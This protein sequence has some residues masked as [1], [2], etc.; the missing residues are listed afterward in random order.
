[1]KLPT[2]EVG[3][4]RRFEQEGLAHSACTAPY[5]IGGS[6]LLWKGAWRHGDLWK[7]VSGLH[8]F[9][10]ITRQ[11]TWLAHRTK[12]A[13]LIRSSQVC[14]RAIDMSELSAPELVPSCLLLRP[15]FSLLVF[16]RPRPGCAH[17][18]DG[19]RL[20]VLQR[21]EQWNS[22]RLRKCK[23]RPNCWYGTTR[24]RGTRVH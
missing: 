7:R 4:R 15:A 1:V 24:M 20:V 22:A 5:S 12:T 21:L 13:R 2:R 8:K 14:F 6:P 11:R 23:G 9:L 19:S 3:R 10:I 16:Q 18:I 17:A